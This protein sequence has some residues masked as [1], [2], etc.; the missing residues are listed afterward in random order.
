MERTEKNVRLG[1]MGEF[2]AS[3]TDSGENI[4]L[5][6]RAVANE[7][8][9][10]ASRVTPFRRALASVWVWGHRLRKL[11]CGVYVRRPLDYAVFT[12][13][14]ACRTEFSVS[15]APVVWKGRL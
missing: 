9:R 13:D 5:T 3:F 1:M 6:E 11:C 2:L 10:L 14:L 8:E 15:R 12:D 4:S 7:R